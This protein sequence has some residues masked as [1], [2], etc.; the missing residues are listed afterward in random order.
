MRRKY[1][2]KYKRVDK[3]CLLIIGVLFFAF[4]IVNFIG[5]GKKDFSERE[6]RE[7]AKFPSIS[8]ET[9]FN[10]SFS[11]GVTDYFNDHFLFRDS[12][13]DLS[14]KLETVYGIDY[15]LDGDSSLVI[16]DKGGRSRENEADDKLARL[17]EELNRQEQS[18]KEDETEPTVVPTD[19]M[20]L[21]KTEMKLTVGSGT[22]IS[23]SGLPESAAA[24][25]TVDDSG[26]IEILRTESDKADIKAIKEGTGVLTCRAAGAALTCTV[27]VDSLAVKPNGQI[28]VD[29]MTNGLFIYR[30]AVY[31]S[32][33]Y[34]EDNFA[35]YAD[36]AAYY[37]QLFSP[38]RMTVCIGPTSGILIDND[39]LR[40]MLPDL[41]AAFESMS[42]VC[43]SRGVNFVDT[44][45]EILA[46]RDEYLYYKTD[47][48]WTGRGAYY[49]YKAFAESVGFV[50][51]PLD[52]FEKIVLNDAYQGSMYEY[53]QD[54]R[55]KTFFDSVEAYMPTKP[56]TMTIH[57]KQGE[58]QTFD[59]SI[60]TWSTSYSAFLCG[61]NPYT[62]INVPSNPQDL[63]ILVLKDSFGNAF[64][65][66][67]AEHYGNIFVVDTR[68]SD[69]NIRDTFADYSFTDVLFVNNIEAASS[70]AWPSLYLA[71]VGVGN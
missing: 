22:T 62:A 18:K 30:D 46:H 14:R 60:M 43:A 52:S 36:V 31:T 28:D 21:S 41:P 23:L 71:A 42:S 7:L 66:Y 34:S 38:Q 58:V 50:P 26:T 48:H 9:I 13:I 35:Q 59:S 70:P 65:P 55:V 39:E 20:T 8:F 24:E 3:A 69:F 5:P 17:L 45:S 2:Q 15:S 19:K 6:K 61:D 56:L 16:L 67:L 57:T 25:W 49:A 12:F 37:K 51:T 64:I 32:G 11:S 40:D 1:S 47:H 53:T 54:E 44:C 10:G 33:F 63:S 4:A 27:T 68:Y 29:F